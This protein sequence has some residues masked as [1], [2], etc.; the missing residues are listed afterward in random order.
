MSRGVNHLIGLG[1]ALVV[2]AVL[3]AVR[4]ARRTHTI[5][6]GKE[7]RATVLHVEHVVPRGNSLSQPYFLIQVAIPRGD[8]TEIVAVARAGY[9]SVDRVPDSGWTAP[10]YYRERLGTTTLVE[11]MGP[12]SRATKAD[13]P[14]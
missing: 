6:H 13:P 11:I 9:W 8:G 12:P 2:M 5:D 14:A 1:I 7:A 4:A 3:A 10:V